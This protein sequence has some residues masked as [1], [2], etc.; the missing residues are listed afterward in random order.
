M[1]FGHNKGSL[2]SFRIIY[3]RCSTNFLV[4]LLFSTL[5]Q[6]SPFRSQHGGL[7]RQPMLKL[8]GV[9]KKVHSEWRI[10]SEIN[11]LKSFLIEL[12][13]VIIRNIDS[14]EL[15]KRVHEYYYNWLG[16]LRICN[17]SFI[18]I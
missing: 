14:V 13:G 17:N 5:F 9:Y 1:L 2:Y 18:N 10:E 15:L 11:L 4:G 7:R 12:Y 16:G 6:I 8:N 3:L